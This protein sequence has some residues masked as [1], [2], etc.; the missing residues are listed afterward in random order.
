[1][2]RSVDMTAEVCPLFLEFAVGGKREYLKSTGIRKYRAV[3]AIKLMQ[4]SGL[5][6][7]IETGAQIEVI[8]IAENDFCVNIIA[9]LTEVYTFNTAVPTGIKI[10]VGTMP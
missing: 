1:M 2:F 3:P 10:G 4:P 8:C 6:Q 7:D 5:S 9:E